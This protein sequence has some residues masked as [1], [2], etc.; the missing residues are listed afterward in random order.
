MV[1]AQH[2]VR[3]AKSDP[4]HELVYA[5]LKGYSYWPAKVIHYI[6]E[7]RYDVRF[8]GNPHQRAVIPKDQIKPIDADLKK[9]TFKKTT[10]FNKSM[11]ELKIHQK[12]LQEQ[13]QRAEEED[14]EDEEEE[15]EQHTTVSSTSISTSKAAK[16][17]RVSVPDDV[18]TSTEEYQPSKSMAASTDDFAFNGEEAT[19]TVSSTQ[20][21]EQ[22]IDTATP[23]P[24]LESS[25]S[26]S[27]SVTDTPSK[28]DEVKSDEPPV[29]ENE[30]EKTCNC[31]SK[32]SRLMV[33]QKER[34]EKHF[35][36]EKA[37]GL[38]ELSER[39]DV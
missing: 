20:T 29:L 7:E 22:T 30:E 32:H 11:E 17:K 9:V 26:L 38:E 13:E 6:N 23:S 35:R 25:P 15:E 3:F 10:G 27:Q 18:V 2:T 5:K 24:S 1:A 12:L 4:P 14:N 36:E 39:L 31:A 34:M 16:R 28:T 21:E 8:F 33:E 19:T 37:R